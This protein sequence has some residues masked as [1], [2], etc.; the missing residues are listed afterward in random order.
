MS[1]TV[2]HVGAGRQKS[3]TERTYHTN[4]HCQ[5]LQREHAQGPKDRDVLPNDWRECKVCAGTTNNTGQGDHSLVEFLQLEST[6]PEDY[7]L[8]AEGHR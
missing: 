6:K 2:W 5:Y 1:V 4:K 7:G 3:G 8:S